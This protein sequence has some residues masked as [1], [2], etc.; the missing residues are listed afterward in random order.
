MWAQRTA[1]HYGTPP[2]SWRASRLAFLSPNLSASCFFFAGP[3]IFSLVVSFYD[4][5]TTG[6]SRSFVGIDNY[7]QALSIDVA[8]S[9]TP[10]AAAKS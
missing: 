10:N 2:T 5:K 6:T 9:P 4:W 3:L 8:S 1:I 7:I